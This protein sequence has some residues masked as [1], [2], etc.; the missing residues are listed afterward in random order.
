MQNHPGFCFYPS[1][2]DDGR[3]LFH[4]VDPTSDSD[5]SNVSRYITVGER[6]RKLKFFLR[7]HQD[8]SMSSSSNE[9]WERDCIYIPLCRSRGS[10]QKNGVEVVVLVVILSPEILAPNGRHLHVQHTY[11]QRNVS[12]VLIQQGGRRG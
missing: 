1:L 4:S 11:G 5:T 7:I 12:S 9:S 2:H 6:C 3:V 10:V 8:P